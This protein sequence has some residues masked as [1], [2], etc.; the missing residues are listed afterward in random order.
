MGA[1]DKMIYPG[2]PN[3]FN[4]ISETISISRKYFRVDL[5]PNKLTTWSE[6]P[7]V[8]LRVVYTKINKCKIKYNILGSGDFN[9]ESNLLEILKFNLNLMKI[10]IFFLNIFYSRITKSYIYLHSYLNI[11]DQLP[12]LTLQYKTKKKQN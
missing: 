3:T 5:F 12:C 7:I 10:V 6:V 11:I 4:I 9:Q 8:T 2:C 1:I